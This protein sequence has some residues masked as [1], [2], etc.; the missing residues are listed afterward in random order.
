MP[1]TVKRI[2]FFWFKT[3]IE[4]ESTVV[5]FIKHYFLWFSENDTFHL[6]DGEHRMINSKWG[7][8]Y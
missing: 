2:N 1:K 3:T 4:W 5:V 6:L 7:V 8:I